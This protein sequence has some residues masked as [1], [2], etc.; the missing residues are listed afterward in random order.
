MFLG[1]LWGERGQCGAGGSLY[2]WLVSQL[3]SCFLP[4]V[5]Q[6]RS[7]DEMS[8]WIHF[9]FCSAVLPG[10]WCFAW[11]F[12]LFFSSYLWNRYSTYLPSQLV[13]SLLLIFSLSPQP[14][15]RAFVHLSVLEIKWL[16]PKFN[17]RFNI[18]H[19]HIFFFSCMSHEAQ[20]YCSFWG[21]FQREF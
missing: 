11:I 18:M 20:A 12:F 19:I 6:H 3:A 14:H 10:S 13:F 21:N 17:I 8:S 7:G 5:H 2:L 4:V 16:N 15:F 1:C 9:L